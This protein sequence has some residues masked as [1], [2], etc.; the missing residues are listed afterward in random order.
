VEQ[1]GAAQW[2]G[3]LWQEQQVVAYT[4]SAASAREADTA[5]QVA[6]W[7]TTPMGCAALTYL[8]AGAPVR[9]AAAPCPRDADPDDDT[10][11]GWLFAAVDVG[12]WALAEVL[13][14]HHDDPTGVRLFLAQMQ[15]L[16]DDP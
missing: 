10:L 3:V 11:D 13:A 7:A 12:D 14:A 16:E 5:A 15:A 8:L 9:D 1:L 6:R 4:V 2:R